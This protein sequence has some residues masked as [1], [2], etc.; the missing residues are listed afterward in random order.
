MGLPNIN[1]LF[2]TAASTAV[3]RSQRGIAAV[4]LKDS[5]EG[6]A[7]GYVITQESEIPAALSEVNRD[8]LAKTLIGYVNRPKKVLAYVLAA[9]AADFTA[10]LDYF[11]RQKINYLAGPPDCTA[12]EA[13]QIAA[14]IKAQRADRRTPKAVLP[15]TPADCEGVLNFTSENIATGEAEY[16]AAGYCGRMA[17]LAAGTPITVSCTYAVLPEVTAVKRLTEEEMDA[18]VDGGQLILFHDGEK[19]K[20]GRGVNSLQTVTEDKGEAFKK[21]KIVDAVDMMRDDIR[22]LTQDGYIGKYA[23]SYDN[24]C[25]LLTAIR[26]YFAELEAEGVL[27]AGKS[28]VEI[29]LEKQKK[30]LSDAQIDVS[31]LS[32]QEIKTADTGSHVFLKGTVGIMDTI[33]DIDLDMEF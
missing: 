9:D 15:N 14:W 20:V 13:A 30:Y 17:G 4:I 27:T 28:A 2:R 22:M 10:A 33:E 3:S 31:S 7:G 8:Y 32:E 19:V 6:T 11:S 23:N 5:A 26:E 16:T 12:D 25:L 29:D 1:I 24:K 18:A 21:I